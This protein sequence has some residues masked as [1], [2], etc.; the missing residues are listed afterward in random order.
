M[1]TV[2][3]SISIKRY[4]RIIHL[5]S[6]DRRSQIALVEKDDEENQTQA[7]IDLATDQVVLPFADYDYFIDGQT[8]LSF[9]RKTTINK[10]RIVTIYDSQ[11]K[12]FLAREYEVFWEKEKNDFM[13]L[14][15]PK[16]KKY[17]IFDKKAY[18]HNRS[19]SEIALDEISSGFKKGPSGEFEMLVILTKDDKKGLYEI[20]R[21]LTHQIEYDDIE[22]HGDKMILSKNGKQQLNVD[23]LWSDECDKIALEPKDEN[24]AYCYKKDAILVYLIVYSHGSVT[25]VPLTKLYGEDVRLAN[26]WLERSN[27]YI[28]IYHF[29]VRK[30]DH[31]TINEVSIT[32]EMFF[33]SFT[34]AKTVTD[35]NKTYDHIEYQNG[36]YLL[37]EG[38]KEMR[39]PISNNKV[40]G[41][42][43]TRTIMLSDTL[44]IE[45]SENGENRVIDG[46]QNM[47]DVIAFGV[48]SICKTD[49]G[50]IFHC[51]DFD[52]V[53]TKNGEEV[54]IS[55]CAKANHLGCG[56]YALEQATED[57][58]KSLYINGEYIAGATGS[59]INIHIEGIPE[60][61]EKEVY[62]T[63]RK[64]PSKVLLL[65][66]LKKENKIVNLTYLMVTGDIELYDDFMVTRSGDF[67]TIELYFTNGILMRIKGDVN[68]DVVGHLGTSKED[69]NIYR[70]GNVDYA[71]EPITGELIKIPAKSEELYIAAYEGEYGTV[72]VN[73]NH[74]NLFRGLC[75]A[76]E[77][78]GEEQFE[79]TLFKNFASSKTL[80]EK[81]PTLVLKPIDKK[82]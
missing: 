2:K 61:I 46:F 60:S 12:Q 28:G 78:V 32:D 7:I 3:K 36:V 35:P 69:G 44:S 74:K 29:I 6:A 27:D 30:S 21:G 51:N 22:I 55:R 4:Y 14:Q 72:V 9:F 64:S 23:S 33:P 70:I 43:Q 57:S 53:Y 80:Q 41:F 15:D 48:K 50:F 67:T 8:D 49:D 75:L 11:K 79:N 25:F 77:D 73:T 40:K 34:E 26:K 5:L 19:I 54:H 16:T 76:I 52:V 66:Y 38:N 31:E 47:N 58:L 56:F 42:D 71:C 13:I 24:I 59:D 37:K 17:H 65:K 20:G 81:Y 68:V 62:I 82:E 18:L 63:V 45:I 39:L 10:E 1:E